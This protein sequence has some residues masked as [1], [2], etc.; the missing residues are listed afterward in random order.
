MELELAVRLT[1]NKNKNPLE[2]SYLSSGAQAN[3][4][5]TFSATFFVW[6]YEHHLCGACV[7]AKLPQSFLLL[8]FLISIESHVLMTESN[9]HSLSPVISRSAFVSFD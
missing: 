7:V 6:G 8:R 1:K 2:V 4:P 5:L 9:C 3:Y